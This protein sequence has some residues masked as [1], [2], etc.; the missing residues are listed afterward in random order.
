MEASD[1]GLILNKIPS[2]EQ[3]DST[4]PQKPEGC[5]V[6]PRRTWEYNINMAVQEVG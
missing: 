3:K 4:K 6:Y 5:R 1:G 2:P